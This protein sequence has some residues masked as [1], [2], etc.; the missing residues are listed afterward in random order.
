VK[1]EIFPCAGNAKCFP[2]KEKKEINQQIK[3]RFLVQTL[4][5]RL[6]VR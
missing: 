5:G 6:K 2:L 1:L 3:K 4:L